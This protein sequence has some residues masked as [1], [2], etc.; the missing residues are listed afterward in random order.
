[1]QVFDSKN[2]TQRTLG[3]CEAMDF[4]NIKGLPCA[5]WVE[6]P[7]HQPVTIEKITNLLFPVA[8]KFDS[9]TI[10]HKSD[11]GIIVL[12][13]TTVNDVEQARKIVIDR[14]LAYQPGVKGKL[15]VQQM[16]NGVAEFLIGFHRDPVVGPVV[17]VGTGGVMV[18]LFNDISIRVLPINTD[19]ISEML[20][21]LK[22]IKLIEGFRGRPLGDR[23]SLENLIKAMSIIFIHNPDIISIDLNPVIIDKDSIW[24]VD[25]MIEKITV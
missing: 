3:L 5:P 7:T 9:P 2:K 14:A 12:G 15:C 25:A 20:S 8:V 6:L 1:M 19:D 11:A 16:A 24:I 18:E 10:S 23:Q 22:C 21:E 13:C 4:L 17:V